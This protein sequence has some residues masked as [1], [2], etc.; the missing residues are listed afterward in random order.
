M[1]P[2]VN[3]KTTFTSFNPYTL[4]FSSSYTFAFADNCTS[5][6]TGTP[7]ACTAY[8]NFVQTEYNL[9]LAIESNYTI[10]SFSGIM[11]SGFMTSGIIVVDTLTVSN[12]SRRS[13]RLY[14]ID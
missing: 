8:P 6:I 11:V 3:V 7:Q 4:D 9:D 5:N 1:V 12:G 10:G 2:A 13:V 14:V